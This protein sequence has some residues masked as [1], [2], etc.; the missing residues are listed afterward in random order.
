MGRW[1]GGGALVSLVHDLE[2]I[3]TVSCTI[4]GLPFVALRD[5]NEIVGVILLKIWAEWRRPSKSGM[6]Q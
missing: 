4:S 3:E 5:L 1:N 2:F 6:S